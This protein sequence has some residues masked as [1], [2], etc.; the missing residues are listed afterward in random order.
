MIMSTTS[1]YVAQPAMS[2]AHI[3][4]AVSVVSRW[5]AAYQTRRAFKKARAD[6]MALD[7]RLLRDIGLDR[8]EI[9][10]ALINANDERRVGVARSP[11]A[12]LGF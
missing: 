3:R 10:S 9:V 1:N 5:V 11:A 6:L 12:R 2:P 8:S 7:D 4:Q